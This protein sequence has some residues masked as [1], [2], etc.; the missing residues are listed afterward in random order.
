MD[1][2]WLG[3]TLEQLAQGLGVTAIVAGF[4]IL[5]A[6]T[7]G[8]LVGVLSLSQ[9]SSARWTVRV[10]VDVFRGIPSLLI[11]LFV[12]FALPQVGIETPPL[13]SAVL[14]LGLWGSASVAEVARGAIVSIPREQTEGARALGMNARQTLSRVVFPQAFRRFIPPYVGQMTVLIQS[15]ALVSIVGVT[16]IQGAARQ[17]IERLAYLTGDSHAIAIYGLVLGAFFLICYPLT[18]LANAL[19]RRLHV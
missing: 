11:L 3:A 2:H 19:E 6:T 13:V 5:L 16:D 1:Q 17:S 18:L 12:F 15:T 7:L 14:G 9:K 10:Y 4:S 8:A